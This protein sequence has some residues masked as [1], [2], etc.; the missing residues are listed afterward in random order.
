MTRMET[1]AHGLSEAGAQHDPFSDGSFQSV[2]NTFVVELTDVDW[3]LKNCAGLDGVSK[4][5]QHVMQSVEKVIDF[6]RR[7]AA[8][9]LTAAGVSRRPITGRP[10][11]PHREQEVVSILKARNVDALLGCRATQHVRQSFDE[12]RAKFDLDVKQA[13]AVADTKTGM[14]DRLAVTTTGTPANDGLGT[15]VD[16]LTESD[17]GDANENGRQKLCKTRGTKKGA[18]RDKCISAL[19]THHRYQGNS[20]DNF[21]PIGPQALADMAGVPS[22]STASD[23]FKDVFGSHAGYK[24][25]CQD[26]DGIRLIAKLK[27][28]NR[29]CSEMPAYG[30]VPPSERER[31]GDE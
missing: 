11:S 21:S 3:I 22:K 13:I 17:G 26:G 15:A 10:F 6:E 12:G 9:L 5:V 25:A 29:D 14:I 1:P 18:S 19:T 16:T 4:A 31:R 28:L 7:H 30:S 27:I 2:V 8:H 24:R 20:V 23:M